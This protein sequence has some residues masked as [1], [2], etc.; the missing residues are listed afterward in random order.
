ME[1]TDPL[2]CSMGK[3]TE[4]VLTGNK[5]LDKDFEVLYI[6][7]QSKVYYCFIMKT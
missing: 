7:I 6:F 3:I 2:R 1:V 4:P 5:V